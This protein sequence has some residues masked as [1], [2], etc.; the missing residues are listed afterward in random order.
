[1]GLYGN[2]WNREVASFWE[3]LVIAVLEFPVCVPTLFVVATLFDWMPEE[4]PTAFEVFS[5]V[6]DDITLRFDTCALGW[7]VW[8]WL[9]GVLCMAE[10][11]KE[12][13][14]K[15]PAKAADWHTATRI[16]HPAAIRIVKFAFMIRLRLA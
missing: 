15:P 6:L 9:E 11:P 8:P 10:P 4:R 5:T 14:P 16:E 2:W 12:L 13:P 7:K 3:T 1:V